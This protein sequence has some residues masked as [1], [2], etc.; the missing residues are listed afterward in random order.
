MAKIDINTNVQAPDEITINLVREDYL[1]TSNTYR[2]FFEICLAVTG[3]IIGNLLSYNRLSDVPIINWIFLLL[4]ISGSVAFI[5]MSLKN[6]KKAKAK[7]L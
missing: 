7:S 1:E 3:A 4:M 5:V 2:L 6:Y